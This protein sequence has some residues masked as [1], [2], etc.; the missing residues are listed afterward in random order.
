MVKEQEVILWDTRKGGIIATKELKIGS[1]VLQS[2]PLAAPS[3][4]HII[5]AI[6]NAIKSEGENL[7]N[8]DEEMTQ[9]QNRILS[10]RVWN[11]NED[12]T[13]VSTKELL[14]TNKSWLGP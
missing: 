8:F 7:L 14:S 11:P 4:E 10:L 13:D 3:E 1:L 2:K 5:E 9:L 12:W 6:S